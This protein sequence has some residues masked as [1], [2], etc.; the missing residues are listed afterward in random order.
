M[1]NWCNNRL[2]IR[3]QP[4]FVDELQQW[5]NGHVVPDYRHAAQQSCRLFLVGCLAY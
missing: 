3:G 5:V 1:S 2:V 4:V